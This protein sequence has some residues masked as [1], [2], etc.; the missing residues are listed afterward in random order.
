MDPATFFSQWNSLLPPK[1][2]VIFY[3]WNVGHMAQYSV[4]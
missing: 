2:T 1:R 3:E 4:C